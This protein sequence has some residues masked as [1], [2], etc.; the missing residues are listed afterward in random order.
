[1]SRCIFPVLLVLSGWVL[2]VPGMEPG[3]RILALGGLAAMA[4]LALRCVGTQSLA[5][6][7]TWIG[8]IRQP[9]Y[10]RW[11]GLFVLAIALA[12]SYT[13]PRPSIESTFVTQQGQAETISVP[14]EAFSVTSAH[15]DENLL[16]R[17]YSRIVYEAAIHQDDTVTDLMLY[18]NHGDTRWFVNGEELAY[19]SND[20]SNRFLLF[21]TSLEPGMHTIRCEVSNPLLPPEVSVS[22]ARVRS[23]GLTPLPL[24]VEQ[25]HTFWASLLYVIAFVL[26]LPALNALILGLSRIAW[27]IRLVWLPPA[28]AIAVGFIV[29]N[30]SL[31]LLQTPVPLEA[32][33]AAFGLMAQQLLAGQ[34]PPLFHYGQ[35]YQGT[36]EVI[37]LAAL[38]AVLPDPFALKL[39]PVLL[40]LGTISVVTYTLWRFAG[41]IHAVCGLIVFA[42]LGNHFFWI[43]GKAWFGY[44]FTLFAG[45]ILILVTLTACQARRLSLIH[46]MVLGVIG[47]LAFWQLP[48]IGP[49]LLSCLFTLVY[50]RFSDSPTG[51][52]RWFYL[53]MGHGCQAYYLSIVLFFLCIS[54]YWAPALIFEQ[55]DPVQFITQGREELSDVSVNEGL[56]RMIDEC[57]PVL[58]GS[59]LPYE[60]VSFIHTGTGS[61][62]FICVF[63]IGVASLFFVKQTY[64]GV[65]SALRIMTITLVLSTGTAVWLLPFGVW[66]WYLT[67]I[68]LVLPFVITVVFR[69][70][71]LYSKAIATLLVLL[72]VTHQIGSYT[73]QTHRL[74]NPTSLSAQGIILASD[75]DEIIQ[76][77]LYHSVSGLVCEHG[78]DRSPGD[79]GRDWMGETLTFYSQGKINAVDRLSRRLPSLAQKRIEKNHVGYLL[80]DDLY[81]NHPELENTER[82][83]PLTG[84]ALSGLFTDILGYK[85]LSITPWNLYIPSD[86]T[87]SMLK[88]EWELSSNNPIFLGAAHDHAISTRAYSRDTYW[89]SGYLPAQG[90]YLRVTFPKA[91]TLDRI[92]LYHGTKSSD[93]PRENT[94]YAYSA[95]GDE[96]ALGSLVYYPQYRSSILILSEPV[97]TDTIEIRVLPPEDNSW[98]TVFELWIQ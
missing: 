77:S 53:F 60:P 95:A 5:W 82:Y 3:S 62:I 49:V 80:H 50:T 66:P 90:G 56:S 10:T 58:L 39:Y 93:Y 45:S 59:A 52:R 26:W 89:S 28:G 4:W 17:E 15:V 97:H 88:P 18:S 92:V 85:H 65:F 64:S 86:K 73:Q 7:K 24:H 38:M 46:G 79:A 33:E 8:D 47:G 63:F 96:Y 35:N 74:Q 51:S 94:V 98:L 9:A 23:P 68:Y 20:A 21:A 25:S 37:P 42:L 76:Q 32:D 1:M 41:A 61:H 78:W 71:W 55:N 81:Y 70:L 72:S 54:P 75:M 34:A 57:V 40:A 84:N 16:L 43:L 12:A 87:S 11:V 69:W 36:F 91:N 48:L 2:L 30:L 22:A 19:L 67:P 27:L 31:P 6:T 13:A 44:G 14:A 29:Y 83:I